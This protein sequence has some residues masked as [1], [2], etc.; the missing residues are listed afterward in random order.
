MFQSIKLQNEQIQK[1]KKKQKKE[2]RGML[3]NVNNV[4]LTKENHEPCQGSGQG[5]E[6][7]LLNDYVTQRTEQR[8][9]KSWNKP[10]NTNYF[11]S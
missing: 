10:I 7:K 3:L 11:Q 6:T 5:A 4:K 2:Q 8:S 1:Q 9:S